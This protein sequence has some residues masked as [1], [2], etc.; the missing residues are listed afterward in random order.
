[1]NLD[2]YQDAAMKTAVFPTHD[3]LPIIYPALG[4]A[5]E[6]GE[7]VDK[8]KKVI[9]AGGS[10][11]EEIKAGIA[12]ELGDVLWYT[13]ALSRQLGF[14][15]STIAEMNISKL[16]DRKDRGVLKSEGDNR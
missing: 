6:T 7:V 12:K 13:A 8:I 11:T 2:A 15:L 3:L 16:A 14:N 1:M 9:R 10:F 4:L 5:G